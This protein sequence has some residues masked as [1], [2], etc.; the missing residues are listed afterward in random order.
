MKLN[1]GAVRES[2]LN[3]IT[4]VAKVGFFRVIALETVYDKGTVF[5]TFTLLD[6]PLFYGPGVK[7]DENDLDSKLNLCFKIHF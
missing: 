6:K 2:L 3:S 4:A 1:Q 5:V 7:P